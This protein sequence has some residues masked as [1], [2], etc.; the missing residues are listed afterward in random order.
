MRQN[1]PL[2]KD[3]QRIHCRR[4]WERPNGRW[5]ISDLYFTARDKTGSARLTGTKA[6]L[7][8]FEI[9]PALLRAFFK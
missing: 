3:D 8:S 5:K 7:F 1:A 4:H 9:R 6:A 2:R